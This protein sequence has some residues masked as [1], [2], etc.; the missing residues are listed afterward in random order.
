MCL[1]L[2]TRFR[3]K[4]TEYTESHGSTRSDTEVY[5]WLSSVDLMQNL[6]SQDR[7]PWMAAEQFHSL[8]QTKRPLRP[9]V[10]LL[11]GLLRRRLRIAVGQVLAYQAAG[12]GV[13][14]NRP[15]WGRM[16]GLHIMFR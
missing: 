3:C 14:V 7:E 5:G 1:K 6:A 10:F 13:A 8:R 12:F 9:F 16:H 2:W 15:G 11:L 4:S